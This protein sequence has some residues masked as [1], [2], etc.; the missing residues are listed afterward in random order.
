MAPNKNGG[1]RNSK[2]GQKKGGKK[3]SKAGKPKFVTE[4]C[5]VRGTL[6]LPNGLP[7]DIWNEAVAD[8]NRPVVVRFPEELVKG[9]PWCVFLTPNTWIACQ[10]CREAKP[11][12]NNMQFYE[13]PM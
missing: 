2:G 9:S 6:R 3:G 12:L 5:I 10:Y 1:K 7:D 4:P 8:N 11:N 13:I